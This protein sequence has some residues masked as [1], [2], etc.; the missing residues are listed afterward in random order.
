MVAAADPAKPAIVAAEAL[1]DASV[2]DGFHGRI[3]LEPNKDAGENDF[4]R[5]VF[6]CLQLGASGS[7]YHHR[8]VGW[9]RYEDKLE[10]DRL[11]TPFPF[12][13]PDRWRR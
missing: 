10:I 2:Q 9:N 11:S 4:V 3:W 5:A 13:I 1:P 8:I 6:S 7:N 12:V